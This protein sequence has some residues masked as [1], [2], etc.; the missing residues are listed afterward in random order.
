MWAIQ[1]YHFAYHHHHHLRFIKIEINAWIKY[2]VIS[3]GSAGIFHPFEMRKENCKNLRK[4]NFSNSEQSQ[5]EF[6]EYF[7]HLPQS[8]LYIVYLFAYLKCLIFNVRIMVKSIFIVY[9]LAVWWGWNSFSL[10]LSFTL[11]KYV[12]IIYDDIKLF[13]QRE[14]AEN[15]SVRASK[16]TREKAFELNIKIPTS[17]DMIKRKF[18]ILYENQVP[19]S[20]F[21]SP[22]CIKYLNPSHLIT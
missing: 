8:N 22:I 19:C 15:I 7:M 1:I 10:S 16:R 11:P 13:I 2:N 6:V 5:V 4:E 20:I 3:V 14:K 21:T 9:W 17:V 12:N 18:K